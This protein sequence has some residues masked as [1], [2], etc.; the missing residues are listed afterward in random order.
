LI[1]SR[2]DQIFVVNLVSLF[3]HDLVGHFIFSEPASHLADRI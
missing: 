3:T 1:N 2:R